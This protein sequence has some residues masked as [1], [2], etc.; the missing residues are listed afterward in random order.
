[1]A[2]TKEQKRERYIN[3][4]NKIQHDRY[5]QNRTKIL[6][7]TKRFYSCSCG[8]KFTAGRIAREHE[9]LLP[10]HNVS[11]TTFSRTS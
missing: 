2:W 5:M 8:I 7:E 1:M 10:G 4:Y 3:G 9:K 6:S 11:Y